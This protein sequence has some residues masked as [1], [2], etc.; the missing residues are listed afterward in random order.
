M[1][2]LSI[3]F[4]LPGRVETCFEVTLPQADHFDAKLSVRGRAGGADFE[5]TRD[6]RLQKSRN[7]TFVQTDKY[8]YQPGQEVKFRVLTIRGWR[9]TYPEIWVTTPSDTRIAQW[10]DAAS[11]S[12]LLHLAFQLADEPEEGLYTI[13]VRGPGDGKK[14][15]SFKVEEF[16]LPRFEVK[17][18]PP[19]FALATDR[20]FTFNV[21]AN[22]TFGQPLKGTVTL[23]VSN[24]QRRKC[25]INI[26]R[27]EP[28]TG[29]KD[30]SVT[31]KE[32]RITDC[33]VF[34]LSATAV[35]EEDGTG[36]RLNHTASASVSRS[37]VNFVTVYEDNYKKPNLPFTLKVKATL[38][39][40]SPAV[41]VP[42][43]VCA[44]GMCTN[45][46]TQED[47]VFTVV[48]ASDD[49]SRVFMSTLN[50]RADLSASTFSKDIR[51]YFSPSN[52][53]LLLQVP[54]KKLKCEA[55]LS[56]NYNLPVWFS[57]NNQ[58]RAS[59]TVQVVS[60]GKIQ[61]LSTRQVS[62]APSVFPIDTEHLVDTPTNPGFP[63]VM[64]VLNLPISLPP[65][66]SPTAQV[67][68]VEGGGVGEG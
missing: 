44:A 53:S 30:I 13:H 47:G 38:P 49:A 54:E 27:T 60:R 29:C 3:P 31:S 67:G 35:V 7:L 56:G 58:P 59:L 62:F 28:I 32:L 1:S 5:D 52:S 8:L 4:L 11:T 22:Y 17:V 50:C 57:A 64:G 40:D 18:T 34:R 19:Q 20:V 61:H 65:T 51:Q 6:I 15:R 66:A 33:H 55:G 39:D 23:T 25:R 26:K 37:A 42:V 68:V 14:T 21:C 12:G 48:V 2:A 45:R 36:V 41:G 16:V 9:A 63:I 10:I 24:N 46:T 43:E